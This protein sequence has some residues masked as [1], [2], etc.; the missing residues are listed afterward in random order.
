MIP[1]YSIQ[2][3]SKEC[4]IIK[5]DLLERNKTIWSHQYKLTNDRIQKEK[6]TKK[7]QREEKRRKESLKNKRLRRESLKEEV[8]RQKKLGNYYMVIYSLIY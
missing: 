8:M 6:S 5:R 2:I 4:R 3:T 1:Y 7:R